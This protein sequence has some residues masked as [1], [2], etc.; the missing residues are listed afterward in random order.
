MSKKARGLVWFLMCIA[1]IIIGAAWARGWS[2]SWNEADRIVRSDTTFT[3]AVRRDAGP[4]WSFH[5]ARYHLVVVDADTSWNGTIVST[6]TLADV[7][8]V[9]HDADGKFS[10]SVDEV[11]FLVNKGDEERTVRVRGDGRVWLD[12]KAVPRLTG[13][14]ASRRYEYLQ[15]AQEVF[16]SVMAFK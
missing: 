15:K 11:R 9:D 12:E 5:S 3:I 8:V 4:F 13:I 1:L 16:D 7:T 10:S 6:E 14:L 2:S